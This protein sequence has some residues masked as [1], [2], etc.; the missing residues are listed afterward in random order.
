MMDAVVLQY[1][2]ANSCDSAFRKLSL[3]QI[4]YAA[5]RGGEFAGSHWGT[6]AINRTYKLPQLD[7]RDYKNHKNKNMLIAPACSDWKQDV[8]LTYGD[9]AIHGVFNKGGPQEKKLICSQFTEVKQVATKVSKMLSDLRADSGTRATYHGFDVEGI[10][11]MTSH[12]ARHGVIEEVESK[13]VVPL[14][15][16]DMTGQDPGVDQGM[17]TKS[18]YH[19][20]HKISSARVLIGERSSLNELVSVFATCFVS[21]PSQ[22]R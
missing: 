12:S 11:G 8:T 19:R 13:G 20:Y 14:A 10:E 5:G 9:A 2:L 15:V 21:D 18:A 3:Q 6:M 7:W 16:S 17:G 4:Y 1:T 22:L